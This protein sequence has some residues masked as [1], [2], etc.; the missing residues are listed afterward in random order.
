[1]NVHEKLLEMR[2]GLQKNKLP[3]GMLFWNTEENK[4]KITALSNLI[5]KA[6]CSFIDTTMPLRGRDAPVPM[7][8]KDGHD[9]LILLN[10]WAAG[11][12][13]DALEA[14]TIAKE[15][16]GEEVNEYIDRVCVNIDLAIAM[17]LC[18]TTT[19]PTSLRELWHR[20]KILRQTGLSDGT[21]TEEKADKYF[22]Q[23]GTTYKKLLRNMNF[24]NRDD[25]TRLYHILDQW[26]HEDALL[27]FPLR[28]QLF[29]YFVAK[30]IADEMQKEDA[31]INL[32]IRTIQTSS[33]AN[34]N[35][36]RHDASVF[37]QQQTQALLR[38]N[39]K[40]IV[41]VDYILSG[42]TNKQIADAFARFG[43]TID[44]TPQVSE[45][46]ILHLLGLTIPVSLLVVKTATGQTM[47]QPHALKLPK[48]TTWHMLSPEKE[49][50]NIA[51]VKEVLMIFGRIHQHLRA[52]EDVA[53]TA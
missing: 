41:V 46:Q 45:D 47:P 35:G 9:K 51:P 4:H 14:Q 3:S 11:K 49:Y 31:T 48:Y 42:R 53:K 26:K 8:E 6:Y 30:G 20:R 33:E 40:H 12:D 2:T 25:F 21:V 23:F 36:M 29:N 7:F 34:E 5:D 38:S 17:G 15:L 44:D 32:R 39:P 27:L 19:E 1:M 28:G 22:A 50:C 43:R 10:K 13:C 16:T 24:T 52:E 37:L 18:D